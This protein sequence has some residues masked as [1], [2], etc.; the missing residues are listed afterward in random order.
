M[1]ETK[2]DFLSFRNC[3]SGNIGHYS[4]IVKPLTAFAAEMYA[5][6]KA[7]SLI[8]FRELTEGE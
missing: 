6:A 7:A 8:Y 5:I 1:V 2:D 3:E 4:G